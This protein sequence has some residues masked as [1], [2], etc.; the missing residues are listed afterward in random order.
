MPIYLIDKIKQ[1]NGKT[2]KL[3]DAADVGT[4]DGKSV[5][6]KLEEI[7]EA[8]VFSGNTE[9]TTP[10]EAAKA[11]T[12][13]KNVRIS[14]ADSNFGVIVFSNFAY[15]I[16]A[17]L[18]VASVIFEF[19]GKMVNASLVGYTSTNAWEFDTKPFEAEEKVATSV[20][21]SG[22]ENGT[23]VEN[24]SDGSTNTYTFEFDEDGK[25]TKITDSDGNETVLNW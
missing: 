5:E 18:V 12:Q 17:G 22:F 8:G 14:H 2:F 10:T 4:A 23:V 1:K 25:I 7:G 13:N 16:N 9:S 24:Y 6:E 21:L 11:I 20:D 15:A 3:L 19:E